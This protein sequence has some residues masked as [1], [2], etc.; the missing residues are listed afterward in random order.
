MEE[1]LTAMDEQLAD[2]S[3]NERPSSIHVSSSSFRS[4][5]TADIQSDSSDEGSDAD[6]SD[7]QREK[8]SKKMRLKDIKC[9]DAKISTK[10]E[11]YTIWSRELQESALTDVLNICCGV[12][13]NFERTRDC[14][15]YNYSKAYEL[16][17]E[18]YQQL[19]PNDATNCEN[20]EEGAQNAEE[21]VRAGSS[22]NLKRRHNSMGDGY[23]RGYHGRQNQNNRGG[24]GDMGVPRVLL[25]LNTTVSDNETDVAKDIAAKLN[26]EKEDLIVRVVTTLGKEK[27]IEL[28]EQ[29]KKIEEDGGMTVLRGTRRRTS[30]GIF[31]FILKNDKSVAEEDKDTVF[32]DDRRKMT[33]EKK[34]AQAQRRRMEAEE[35]RRSLVATDG[36][37]HLPS[38]AELVTKQGPMQGEDQDDVPEGDVVTNPPPS[39]AWDARENG[40][41]TTAQ[42]REL[43]S[44]DDILDLGG[45]EDVMDVF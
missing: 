32:S 31:L 10:Q 7:P 16:A 21:N 17:A 34:E 42:E 29:T 3:P 20:P 9:S 44:Y 13:G 40:V 22:R 15:S 2:Y 36:L 27:A 23:R 8:E 26:E 6:D 12:E 19:S 4:S 18:R 45:G 5:N 1:E 37:T 41:I 43:N 25:P 24:K 28:Y 35:L 39:P 38:R 33:R 11:K 30:G 14:E